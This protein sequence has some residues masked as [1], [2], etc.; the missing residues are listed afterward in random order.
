L[1]NSS[2]LSSINNLI[3]SQAKVLNAG[4]NLSSDKSYFIKL[5][6]LY[7]LSFAQGLK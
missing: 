7:S 3:V 4:L 2:S 1:I 5:H 6:L